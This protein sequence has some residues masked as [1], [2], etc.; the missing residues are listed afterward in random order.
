MKREGYQGSYLVGFII[1]GVVAL[2]AILFYLDS[3]NLLV[4]I[5]LIAVY[6]LYM[7]WS[8]GCRIV[9]PGAIGFTSRSKRRWCSCFPTC[10]RFWIS[11]PTCTFRCAFRWYA[12]FHAQPHGCG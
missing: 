12:R 11:H 4:A 6:S 1:I 7:L 9:L 3:P 2:R 5:A 10:A 8:R